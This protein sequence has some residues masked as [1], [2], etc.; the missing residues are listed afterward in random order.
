MEK[1]RISV[2][3]KGIGFEMD[4]ST[5]KNMIV[6][7]NLPSNLADEAIIVLKENKKIK[8][9]DLVDKKNSD[10]S[11]TLSGVKK[12]DYI[13][14]EAEYIVSD[15]LRKIENDRNNDI[16]SKNSYSKYKKI[17]TYNKIIT[18]IAIISIILNFIR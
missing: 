14:K 17:K 9:K 11:K 1:I 8:N 15:Y 2:I 6:L 16:F 3:W 4:I 10:K 12:E 18:V 5:M 7:R 13:I